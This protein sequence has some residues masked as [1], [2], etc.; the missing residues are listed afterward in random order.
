MHTGAGD[1]PLPDMGILSYLLLDHRTVHYPRRKSVLSDTG[2]RTCVTSHALA[3]INDH[4]PPALIH[5]LFQGSLEVAHHAHKG[6]LIRMGIRK[7]RNL[8]DSFGL[9]F[10]RRGGFG[11]DQFRSNPGK[12]EC[13]CK[14][15]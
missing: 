4:H 10:L 2:D 1:K 3:Q 8:R 13:L 14:R 6:I 5:R 9:G 11:T 12:K 15:L 7:V